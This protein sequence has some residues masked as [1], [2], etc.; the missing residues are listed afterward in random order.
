MTE[1]QRSKMQ[2]KVLY[3]SI[4]ILGLAVVFLIFCGIK[5]LMNSAVLPVGMGTAVFAYWFVSDVLSVFWVKEFEG[6]TEKQ[7]HAYYLFAGMDLIALG[8]LVYFLIDMDSMTGVLVYV[9]F[10]MT[11]KRYR[12]EFLGAVP[13]ENEPELAG[14]TES[15]DTEVVQETEENSEK[16]PDREA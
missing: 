9:L 16:E 12:D 4:A 7:K 10:N 13:K 6:K 15:G 1:Q 11:K 14:D 3:I 5:G 8:G 2:K